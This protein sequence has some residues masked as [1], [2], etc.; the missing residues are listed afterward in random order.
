MDPQK[1][2]LWVEFKVCQ[3]RVR[4]FKDYLDPIKPTIF[5]FLIM[6]SL[7]IY[8]YIYIYRSSKRKVL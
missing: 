7:Y 3:F 5:G 2:L 4:G 8:I 1:E 6:I